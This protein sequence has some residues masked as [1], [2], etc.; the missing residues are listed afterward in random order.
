MLFQFY[1]RQFAAN[2]VLLKNINSFWALALILFAVFLSLSTL[3]YRVQT[4]SVI[5]IRT[6]L[7][8]WP[9]QWLEQTTVLIPASGPVYS[10]RIL[11]LAADIAIYL[12]IS[13]AVSYLSTFRDSTA[14][15][16]SGQ[17]P[18]IRIVSLVI[19]AYLTRV[20]SCAVHEVIGHGLW[21]LAL[22]AQRISVNITFLGFGW[23]SWEPPLGGTEGLL[24]V[25][26]GLISSFTVGTVILAFLY[27]FP[28]IGGFYSRLILFL[29]GF[30]IAVT[31]SSYLIVGGLTG[32]GD[33]GFISNSLGIDYLYFAAVGVA[34]FV[35]VFF[36]IS[37][38]FFHELGI[39]FPATD[40]RKLLSAFWFTVPL[41]VLTFG[42]S[43][44]FSL[45]ALEF[46]LLIA[47]SFI[48]SIAALPMYS[49]FRKL[50]VP[51]RAG[52][53]S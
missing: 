18:G 43:E 4:P 24:A 1:S 5:S 21:A 13:A 10:V 45:P 15:S 8:G 28:R 11:Q 46:L 38:M 9:F 31:Q 7:F 51:V 49:F 33:I 30:W 26:G 23:C 16:L 2:V 17:L 41:L 44:E 53:K 42:F 27:Y 19:I 37:A 29:L 12:S 50:G 32:F 39:M 48:P 34:I 52:K 14:G 25:A 40:Q 36:V 20:L 47:L 3:F 35:L 22:G 6:I